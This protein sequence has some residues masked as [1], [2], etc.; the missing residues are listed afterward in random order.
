MRDS[1]MVPLSYRKHL[2]DIDPRPLA[3]GIELPS[4]DVIL[5][6]GTPCESE[7]PAPA[8]GRISLT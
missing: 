5:A 6:A 7:L 3:R 4:D 2:A 1:D 8:R